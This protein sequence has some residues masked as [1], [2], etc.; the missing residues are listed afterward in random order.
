M[1]RGNVELWLGELLHLQQ[2]SLHGVIRDCSNVI[3]DQAF[4]LLSFIANYPAQ[5]KIN[6]HN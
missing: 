6:T 5:V 3:N 2:K 4:E 1:A